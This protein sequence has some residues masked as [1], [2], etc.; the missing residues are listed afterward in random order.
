MAPVVASAQ[1]HDSNELCQCAG[2]HDGDVK[3]ETSERGASPKV[4][5]ARRAH[6]ESCD[7]Q[8]KESKCVIEADQALGAVEKNY[9]IEHLHARTSARDGTGTSNTLPVSSEGCVFQ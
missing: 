6:L 2:P 5:E 9:R 7:K 3:G 4:M 1:G 8:M